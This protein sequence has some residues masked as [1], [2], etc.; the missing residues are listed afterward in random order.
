MRLFLVVAVSFALLLAIHHVPMFQML[1][2][3]E[4]LTFDQCIGWIAAGF[5]SDYSAV[6]KSYALS[7][8]QGE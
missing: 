7:P 1:F 3:I 5:I 2:Q 4:P 8:K 6:E